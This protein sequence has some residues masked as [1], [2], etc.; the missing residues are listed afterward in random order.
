MASEHL[1]RTPTSEGSRAIWTWSGWLKGN[2]D[3]E[4]SD[5]GGSYW[6]WLWSALGLSLIHI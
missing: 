3:E 5:D 1:R 6:H 4:Y 2:I